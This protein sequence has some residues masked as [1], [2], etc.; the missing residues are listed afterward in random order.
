MTQT[1]YSYSDDNDT[2]GVPI[3]TYTEAGFDGSVGNV[4]TVSSSF[5]SSELSDLTVRITGGL[6]KLSPATATTTTAGS[7]ATKT[8]G[9]GIPKVTGSANLL[10]GGALAALALVF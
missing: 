2:K 3:T 1:E 6:E 5:A 10:A 9:N 7:E 8:S 4:L